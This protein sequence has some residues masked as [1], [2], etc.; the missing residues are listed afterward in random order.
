M[1]RL[2]ADFGFRSGFYVMG[3]TFNAG[4][5]PVGRQDVERG[6]IAFRGDFVRGRDNYVEMF[7]T[8]VNFGVINYLGENFSED[9][10]LTILTTGLTQELL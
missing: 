8:L 1:L 4:C 2:R 5:R 7:R 6:E 9:S 10:H 3:C